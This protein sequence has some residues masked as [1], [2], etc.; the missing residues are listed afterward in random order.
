MDRPDK[1]LGFEINVGQL[2]SLILKQIGDNEADDGA[3]DE[4][5]SVRAELERLRK[6]SETNSRELTL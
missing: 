5:S 4:I 2:H 6:A 1:S 3:I